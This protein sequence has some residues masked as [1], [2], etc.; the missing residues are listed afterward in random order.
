MLT[1]EL[2]LDLMKE[3]LTGSLFAE[4]R[5]ASSIVGNRSFASSAYAL[6]NRILRAGDL[7]LC[8]P[9]REERRA[10]GRDWPAAGETMMGR[11]RLRNLQECIENVLR[12]GIPGDLI[13]TG[14]WRGGG[15]I[16]MRAVLKAWGIDDRI[17]WV[18]DSFRGLPRADGRYAEDAGDKHWK[19]ARVL[20]VS[21]DEVKANFV[22]YG[23]LDAQVRFIEGWFKTACRRPESVRWRYFVWMAICTRRR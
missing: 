8:R 14:V 22:R 19:Q 3:C 12:E 15:C 20:S 18:A 10:E 16:F 23:L 4:A 9:Y 1:R 6:I 13:E 21:L 5:G 7:E 17:V 2:Y 11:R